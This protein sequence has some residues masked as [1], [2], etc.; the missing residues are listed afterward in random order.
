MLSRQHSAL[1]PAPPCCCRI[2][3]AG[4]GPFVFARTDFLCPQL[5]DFEPDARLLF[6][7]ALG[8]GGRRVRLEREA[9]VRAACK[10]AA[11]WFG[12]LV[13]SLGDGGGGGGNNDV[14][15]FGTAMRR[16]CPALSFFCR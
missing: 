2:V 6:D 16:P 12:W 14:F 5:G 3:T 11:S 13:L 4:S 1:L 8:G 9:L 10:R 15:V 7:A